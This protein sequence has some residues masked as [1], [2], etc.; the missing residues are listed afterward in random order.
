METPGDESGKALY[1]Y[2][3]DT[4]P[5][6]STCLE[7]CAKEFPPFL[8]PKGAKPS[9]DFSLIKRSDTK[10]LQWSYQGKPLYRYAAGEDPAGAP[11]AGDT[12]TMDREN[13]DW[14]N[15]G[16]QLLYA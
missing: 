10:A 15:P 8:A 9:G 5:N 11:L 1:T 3:Q 2:D 7:T 16:Q 4:S 6:K 12:A 13:P 14:Y